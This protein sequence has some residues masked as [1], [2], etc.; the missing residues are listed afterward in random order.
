M[1][2]S[3]SAKAKNYPVRLPDSQQHTK[4]AEGQKITGKVFAGKST[5]VEI[6]DRFRLESMYHIK[7]EEWAKISGKGKV[8]KNGK[9]VWAELHW[10]EANGKKY[11]IKIKRYLDES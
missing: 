8:I 4:L 5:S 3:L 9:T 10:Y 7:A 6:R 2:K 11:E 1:G